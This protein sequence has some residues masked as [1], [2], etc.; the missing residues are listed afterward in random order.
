M[1]PRAAAAVLVGDAL[2]RGLPAGTGLSALPLPASVARHAERGDLEALLRELTHDPLLG[3][4][5]V[6]WPKAL[7]PAL[8]RFEALPQ[9]E[10]FALH[11]LQT[12][13]YV[14]VVALIQLVMGAVLSLKV[15]PVLLKLHHDFDTPVA[16]ELSG[17]TSA[18]FLL[19]AIPVVL[20]LVG[21]A[22][23]WATL[24]GWGRALL[25]AKEAAVAA[26]LVESQAPAEVR[27][28]FFSKLKWVT[29]PA[30]A[31]QV[32]DLDVVSQRSTADATRALARFLAASRT[33]SYALLTLNAIGLLASVYVTAAQL[34][35]VSS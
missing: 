26:A 5:A 7:A 33:V 10:T 1:T 2:E 18:V 31:G 14:F 6:A 19:G 13:G 29:A 4:V 23:G 25:R 16:L 15:F 12:A 22:S 35:G 24:P 20:W 27:Q 34:W 11:A 32:V 21:G 9:R 8:R 28:A 30:L 17:V 3:K